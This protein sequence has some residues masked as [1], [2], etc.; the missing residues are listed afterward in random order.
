MRTATGRVQRR[1]AQVRREALL[2][3]AAE[4]FRESGF[5]VPLEQIAERAGVGR[6][7]LYRNFPDRLALAIA[8][9]E[10]EIDAAAALIDP[11]APIADTLLHLVRHGTRA[12]AMFQRIAIDIPPTGENRDRFEVLRQQLARLLAP[13][14]DH[15]HADGT[16]RRDIDAL[17]L[18]L[19]VR[20][21]SG[22]AKQRFT[23]QDIDGDLTLALDL[24]QRGLRP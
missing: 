2:T 12:S 16:L 6:G 24:L 15:A 23:D 14:A 20:M 10:R 19:V 8:I 11:A 22:L 9:L 21:L 5:E 1:D 4:C 7:T 3:A 13:L 17:D 18:V